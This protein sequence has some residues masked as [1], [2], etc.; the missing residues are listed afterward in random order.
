MGNIKSPTV[1]NPNDL[2]FVFQQHF[3]IDFSLIQSFFLNLNF[4][5]T[6]PLKIK[7]IGLSRDLGDLFLSLFPYYFY[8]YIIL[9]LFLSGIIKVAPVLQ[10]CLNSDYC[11][12]IICDDD[13]SHAVSTTVI[14]PR[15][16]SLTPQNLS[17]MLL[18]DVFVFGQQPIILIMHNRFAHP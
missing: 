7:Q 15:V 18:S 3:L 12:Y 2:H 11:C 9:K 10:Y 17:Q 8:I 1:F 14:V 16:A 4:L 5:L 13:E 6:L